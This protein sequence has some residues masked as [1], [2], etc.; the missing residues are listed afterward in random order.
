MERKSTHRQGIDQVVRGEATG[1]P[2]AQ[3]MG[4]PPQG[5]RFTAMTIDI[6]E[7]RGGKIV[8]THHVE[9]WTSAVHQLSQTTSD[10]QEK[11]Q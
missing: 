3:F 8:R 10:S 7:V 5:K 9:D 6:H 1:T 11:S 4:V 2:V